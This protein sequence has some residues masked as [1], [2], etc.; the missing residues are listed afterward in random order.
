MITER[1]RALRSEMAKHHIDVYLI[2][3]SDFH[4]SE[5]VGEYFKSRSF[6][7]GFTGSAGTAVVTKE[8][9]GLFTDGRYFIQ[10]EKQLRGTPVTLYK[11]GEESVPTVKEF[12]KDRLPEEGCL[13]FDGRVVNGR[14][15]EELKKMADKKHA[16]LYFEADLIDR[17]WQ[18]RPAISAKPV[19]LLADC[20]AG[21]TTGQKL[22][23]V[24]KKMSACK[25]DIQI[26][27]SLYDIAWLFNVRGDDIS[28]VPVVISYAAIMEQECVWFVQEQCLNQEVKEY[29]QNNHIKVKSY[30]EFYGFVDELQGERTVLLD[31]NIV[32]YRIYESLA[33]R[34]KI[35]DQQNPQEL[36]RSIKNR[37][38]LAHIREAHRK[39]GVAFT[40]FMYWVKER[41]KAGL[42]LT[43]TDAAAYLE[44]R[45]KEQQNFIDISFDT[46]CAYE[47]NAAMMHYSAQP[48]SCAVLEP[49][50]FLLVDS[51]GHYLEGSTDITR[52]IALG[53]LTDKQ[54]EHFTAVCRA[55][56]NLSA[57]KFLYGCRGINLDILAR[58]PIWELGLDYKCG[59]GHGIGYLLNVHEG[60][61][62]I[63]WKIMP[64]RDDSC[65]LEEGMVT[66][67][68][69]GIYLEGQ[70][71][72]RTENELI[73]KKSEKNEYGQFMYFETV[74][75]A[76]IDLDAILPERM[77]EM[78]RR[79][80]ND[81]HK[82]VFEKLS[83]CFTEKEKEWLKHYT[84]AI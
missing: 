57:A 84:R 46:I 81:Y 76:P 59:T 40:K 26:L 66:T 45:R 54:K 50:G 7:T 24:R 61:N 68:E 42:K 65:I 25:A 23:R 70:Y 53:E 6:L 3:T 17:I 83:V 37:T 43:E 19:Y 31:K 14:L 1:I 16:R 41:V 8:E 4:E 20:Y 22:T 82:L 15:G 72:I 64:E 49:K 13:G 80:L 44:E 9:A 79:L 32:N 78:E 34:V 5:Y 36:M 60:P 67:N 71:G 74:T 73:C 33:A 55:N 12:I 2:P 27:T 28:H 11:S 62:G 38:E 75:Y 69:P 39:D 51:G 52:T 29:L 58:G 63:R 30:E 18:D 48:E 21:E 56:L 77:N 35:V 47:E 10:A